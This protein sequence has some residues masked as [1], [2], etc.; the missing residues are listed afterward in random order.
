MYTDK[1]IVLISGRL[2]LES[3]KK[4]E[5]SLERAN[6]KIN[7]RLEGM[8]GPDDANGFVKELKEILSTIKASEYFLYFD[9][10]ELRVSTPQMVPMLEGC[11]KMY[12][13]VGFKR[14][15]IKVE[16]NPT[17]RMQLSR[18]ARNVGLN[19]EVI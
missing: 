7:I 6:Q 11:F 5:M 19:L 4:Y 17:L 12:K 18:L 3:M 8:F 9:A 15:A 14:V 1:I 2:V 10:K 16:N 13:E